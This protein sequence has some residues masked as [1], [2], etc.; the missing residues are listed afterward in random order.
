MPHPRF[1]NEEIARRGEEIYNTRLR[2]QMEP[3]HDG[4][5][6]IIGIETGDYEVGADSLAAS[7]HA[8]AKHPGA[9]LYGIRVGYDVVESVGGGPR[10]AKR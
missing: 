10:H 9:A 3:Q 2:E 7:K 6:V 1:S 5:I 4:Q 8:L